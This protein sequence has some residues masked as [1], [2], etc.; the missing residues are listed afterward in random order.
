MNTVYRLWWWVDGAPEDRPG[1]PWWVQDFRTDWARESLLAH[2]RPFLR[3]WA[4]EDVD[5][6][7]PDYDE[8]LRGAIGRGM[9]V[10]PKAEIRATVT[11]EEWERAT[12]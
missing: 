10:Q 2:L 3:D 8:D 12:W 4:Q 7:A 6:S 5:S 11:G 9:P 1:G